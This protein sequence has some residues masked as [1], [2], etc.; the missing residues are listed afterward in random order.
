[1]T[2]AESSEDRSAIEFDVLWIDRQPNDCLSWLANLQRGIT[3]NHLIEQ[4]R[5]D[6]LCYLKGC[7]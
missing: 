7:P 1:M 5:L 4:L 3:F 2:L 6:D